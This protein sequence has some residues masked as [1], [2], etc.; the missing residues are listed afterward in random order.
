MKWSEK[1]TASDRQSDKILPCRMTRGRRANRLPG[2]RVYY[3]ILEDRREVY[4]L[5]ERGNIT[6][7]GPKNEVRPTR[8]E[9]L[10]GTPYGESPVATSQTI[11]PDNCN[12]LI[13]VD[14]YG[15]EDSVVVDDQLN[16][17]ASDSLFQ[18]WCHNS[19]FLPDF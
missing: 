16:S 3:L 14:S 2:R 5:G 9:R 8:L 11:E 4:E 15:S 19:D 17:Q 1:L 13:M 12:E 10:D 18:D 7:R 6:T